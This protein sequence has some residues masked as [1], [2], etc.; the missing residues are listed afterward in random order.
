[1]S[2]LIHNIKLTKVEWTQSKTLCSTDADN[3]DW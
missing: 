3:D 1:M 2:S